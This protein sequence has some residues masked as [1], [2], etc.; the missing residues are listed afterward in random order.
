MK[1]SSYLI[2]VMLLA[3]C[4]WGQAV[5][6]AVTKERVV[7]HTDNMASMLCTTDDPPMDVPAVERKDGNSS[8]EICAPNQKPDFVGYCLRP[9][10]YCTDKTRILEHDEQ[11]PPKYWCRKVQP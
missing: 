7:C 5:G 2:A 4:A 3:G 1:N 6:H 9:Y 10:Y 8:I 11:T